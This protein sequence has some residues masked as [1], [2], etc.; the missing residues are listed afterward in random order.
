YGS[1]YHL[2]TRKN[3]TLNRQTEVLLVCGIANPEPLKKFLHEETLTYE[4]CYYNDH[5]IFSIDDLTE[6]KTR[7]QQMDATEKLIITTEK[8]AVRLIKFGDELKDISFYV[9]PISVSFLFAETRA[10]NEL[11]SNFIEGFNAAKV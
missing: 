2:V 4:A 5:H 8:D 10:F 7:F 1:P 9:L 11:I 3:I 6:I